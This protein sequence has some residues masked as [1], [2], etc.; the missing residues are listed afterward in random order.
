MFKFNTPVKPG[1][2]IYCL[3]YDRASK[4]YHIAEHKIHAVTI[5]ED[6]SWNA[7]HSEGNCSSRIAW[8][9]F[10]FPSRKKAERAL[11]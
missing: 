8:L 5:Y 1:Q 11:K 3:E 4:S 10:A 2:V 9:K 6:G 7:Y